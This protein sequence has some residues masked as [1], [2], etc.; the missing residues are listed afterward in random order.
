MNNDKGNVDVYVD[1]VFQAT[2]DCN[3]ADRMPQQTIFHADNLSAQT[4]TVRL[5]NDDGSN[6]VVDAFLVQKVP[7]LLVNDTEATFDHIPSDWAYSSSRGYGDYHGDIHYSQTATQYLQYTFNGT[8]V[9]W[10]GELNNDES[11][12]DVYLDGTYQRTVNCYSTTRE[13][14]QRLFTAASLSAGSHTLKLV[15][16]DSSYMVLDAFAIVPVNFMLTA[17]PASINVNAGGV[18]DWTVNVAALAGFTN[19]V[20]LSVTGVPPQANAV[21]TPVSVE[22]FGVSTLQVSTSEGTPS[23]IYPLTISGVSGTSTNSV[24]VKLTVARLPVNLT[25]YERAVL[26]DNPIGYWPLD[27]SMDTNGV[28]ADLSGNTNNGTYVHISPPANKVPGPSSNI[29]NSV[30]F[31]GATT[32]VDLSGGGNTAWLNFGGPI[33][34]EAWVQLAASQ[35]NQFGDIVAKGYDA[36]QNDDELEMRV[37]GGGFHGGTYNG[38]VGDQGVLY[39]PVTTNWTYLVCTWDGTNWNLYANAQL[40]STSPDTV[41]ALAFGDPWAIGDGT[42]SGNTRFFTGNICQVAFYSRALTP[43]Q[44][45]THYFAAAYGPPARPQI[46]ADVQNP[47]FAFPGGAALNSVGVY[48][49]LPLACQWRFNGRNLTD[50]S[51]ITG[52]LSNVLTLANVQTNE[53]GTYQCIVSNSVGSVTSSP[54]SL[55]L[56]SVPIS[57]TSFTSGG[58]GWASNQPAG[59]GP[60]GSAPM[61]TNGVL[62]LTDGSGNEDRSFFLN[63]P[64]YIGA[65]KASWTYR[66]VINGADGVAFCLQNDPRGEAAVGGGGGGLGVSGITPSAELEFN[67]YNGGGETVG[68]AF[69]TNGLTGANGANGNYVTPGSVNITS[70]DPI[71]VSL[72]YS[73]STLS[74][75]LT[76]TVADLSFTT[77]L[78]VGNLAK[79]VG[80]STAYIGFTGADGA[81]ASVQDIS[82]FSFVSIPTATLQG[83][84]TNTVVL[85]WPGGNYGYT[86]QMNSNLSTAN[87][88]NVTNPVNVVG[89]QNQVVIPLRASNA[90]Y[91]LILQ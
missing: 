66:A 33:T 16:D 61:L 43:A 36:G 28:A 39:G 64:Q 51:T 26:N 20:I 74:L 78:P 62:K 75:T 32:S 27:L 60:Y 41:G 87:W 86:L 68:Y 8:G 40:M 22:S 14:Q 31:D 29:S 34:M 73:G 24:S 18:A 50:G 9:S 35:F 46:Y 13:A 7:E 90:F 11:N 17:T 23:G 65:F 44:V 84:G 67:L 54:A 79:V 37:N 1:G 3:S 76:D 25:P 71:G 57:F 89:G 6:L 42:I 69:Y 38:T 85:F 55:I 12:V 56:G 30:S 15:N 4:H 80:G 48:G 58:G 82:N 19:S 70:G 91:R 83:T 52:S 10:I 47:F 88:V 45:S 53:A 5:V 21:F 77:N 59:T 2:V 72:D 49:S 63:F 81:T